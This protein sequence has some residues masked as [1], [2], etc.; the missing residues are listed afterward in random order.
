MLYPA[1]CWLPIGNSA[2]A[3]SPSRARHLDFEPSCW[4]NDG[5]K[6]VACGETAPR[7]GRRQHFADAVC[8]MLAAAETPGELR[9]L[10]DS[11]CRNHGGRYP[12]GSADSCSMI[13]SAG[14]TKTLFAGDTHASSTAELLLPNSSTLYPKHFTK[15]T[16]SLRTVWATAQSLVHTG[17]SP[18]G[19]R[20]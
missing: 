13:A 15:P 20:Y 3:G 11:E 4:R 5:L 14:V 10:Q 9:I 2:P 17:K 6:V 7:S 8:R 16:W 19:K 18:P 12:V 1:P